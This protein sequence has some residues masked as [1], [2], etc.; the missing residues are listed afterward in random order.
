MVTIYKGIIVYINGVYKGIFGLRERHDEDYTEANYNI[1]DIH[2]ASHVSYFSTAPN[3]A[4]GDTERAES[5][6]GEVYDV[7]TKSSATYTQ[8]DNLIDVDNFMK[9]MIAEMFST[10]YDYPQ[11]NVTIWRPLDNSMKWRWILYDM[12]FSFFC[13]STKWLSWLSSC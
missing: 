6:F 13:E 5:T 7:Y 11:N 3:K 8:M 10:N 9:A 4:I 2:L 12:D 1:E